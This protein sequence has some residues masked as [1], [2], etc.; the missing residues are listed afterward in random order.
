[1]AWQGIILR[2]IQEIKSNNEDTTALTSEASGATMSGKANEY[3][4]PLCENYHEEEGN[5][6]W[7]QREEE[8]TIY[9]DD[10]PDP[11]EVLSSDLG[12]DD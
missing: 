9:G 1:M 6:A 3:C 4:C 12:N 2:T 10:E 5:R 7:Q 8:F 11:F